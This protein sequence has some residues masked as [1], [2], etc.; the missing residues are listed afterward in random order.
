MEEGWKR[1]CHPLLRGGGGAGKGPSHGFSKAQ[2]KALAAMCEALIPPL[3]VEELSI[4]GG[5][6]DPPSKS[7]QAFYRASGA[8]P[9][10]P[11]EVRRP[12]PLPFPLYLLL[13]SLTPPPSVFAQVAELIGK[14]LP[15]AVFLM[16]AA[17]W[18][19]ST[20]LGTL[21]LCGLVCFSGQ[22]PFVRRFSELPL[23]KREKLLQRWSRATFFRPLRLVFLLVKILTLYIFFTRVIASLSSQ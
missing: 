18:A 1:E 3:E 4:P 23:G 15:E 22:F 12:I 13:L 14:G 20:R 10:L 16:R 9:P 21:T 8:D 6:E 2:V 11:D 7:L 19:L 5:R 17:L